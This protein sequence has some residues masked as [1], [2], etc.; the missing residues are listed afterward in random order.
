[1]NRSR[2]TTATLATTAVMDGEASLSLS[3]GKD[4]EDLVIEV[5]VGTQVHVYRS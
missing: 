3:G 4:A 2:L 1:M 5:P